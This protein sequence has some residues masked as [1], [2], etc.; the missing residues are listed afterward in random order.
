MNVSLSGGLGPP[1]VTVSDSGIKGEAWQL[2]G[3]AQE[4]TGRARATYIRTDLLLVLLQQSSPAHMLNFG[5][6]S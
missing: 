6:L 5:Y 3:E 1:S 4:E 2:E